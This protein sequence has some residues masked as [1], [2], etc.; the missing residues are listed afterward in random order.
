MGTARQKNNVGSVT[1]RR[2]LILNRGTKSVDDFANVLRPMITMFT[3]FDCLS[4]LFTMNMND[5]SV[6]KSAE[7]LVEV[8]QS[9]QSAKNIRS[10]ISQAKINLDDDKI[11]CEIEAGIK[12]V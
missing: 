10:L 6:E 4:E 2:S 9:C 5:E 12:T 7:R 1:S 11:L 8:V 3:M